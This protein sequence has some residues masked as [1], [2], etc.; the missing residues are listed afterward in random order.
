MGWF[1]Y[2]IG[3]VWLAVGVWYIL[4]TAEARDTLRMVT[5]QA[6][7]QVFAVM[8]FIVGALLIAAAF[9]SHKIWAVGVLGLLAVGKGLYL[10][11][12]PGKTYA[13]LM[14]WYLGASDQ[15]YRFFGIVMVVLGTAMLSWA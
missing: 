9:Y 13:A 15:T 1:I 11:F 5:D 2:L 14:A 7:R 12:D 3:V 4:Y 6:P 10:F 8:A